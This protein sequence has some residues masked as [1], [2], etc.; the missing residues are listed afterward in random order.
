MSNHADKKGNLAADVANLLF[1]MDGHFPEMS[2]LA[3]EQRFIAQQTDTRLSGSAGNAAA[4]TGLAAAWGTGLSAAAGT[5]N[6]RA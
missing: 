6:R 3:A 5:R 2:D 1:K 4:R